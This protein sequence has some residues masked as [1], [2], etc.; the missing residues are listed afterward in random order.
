M[1]EESHDYRYFPEPDLVNL[2]I[3][4]NWLKEIKASLPE[5][6][7][8]RAKRFIGQYKIPEY[9]AAV[10]TESRELADYY[11]AVMKDFTDGKMASNWIMTELLKVINEEKAEVENYRIRPKML[12]ELLGFV[13]SGK[14][15]GKIAKDVFEEMVGTSRP[16]GEII[17][18]KGLAQ[19][20]D[21]SAIK[22]IVE[23]VIA[24]NEGN[25]KKYLSGKTQLFGFFVG[26][27]MKETGGK[28][29]PGLVNKLL[30]EKLD[31]LA[32]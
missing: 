17:E 32:G 14:I 26:Q 9:D 27:V 18:S 21:D 25:L 29:N 13:Q 23:K 30:K 22:L 12:A 10:L 11:E 5:L 7:E 2:I 8:A 24:E 31:E 4:E 15:S 3:D 1:K 20:S 28:A 16:A 19:I 6:A